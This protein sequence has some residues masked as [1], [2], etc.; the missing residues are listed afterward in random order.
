MTKCLVQ[1]GNYKIRRVV[2]GG[3]YPDPG[4]DKC[5]SQQPKKILKQISYRISK[6][7]KLID[8]F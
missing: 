5:I 8:S 3:F 7:G 4:L 2:L 6:D 1:I